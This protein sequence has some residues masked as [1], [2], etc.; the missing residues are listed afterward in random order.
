MYLCSICLGSFNNNDLYII[1]GVK[2]ESICKSCLDNLSTENS[3]LP[4]ITNCIDDE[5]FFLKY[6]KVYIC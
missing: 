3:A 5:D 4:G 2:K 1:E 6:N